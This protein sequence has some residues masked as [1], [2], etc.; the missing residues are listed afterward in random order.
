MYIRKP[1]LISS[2]TPFCLGSSD[3]LLLYVHR[4][5]STKGP[6]YAEAFALKCM[7]CS[8]SGASLRMSAMMY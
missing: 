8:A 1:Q 5:D 3:C 6:I 4:Q 2:N 7:S